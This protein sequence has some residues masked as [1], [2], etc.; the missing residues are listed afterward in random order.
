MKS[1]VTKGG[2]FSPRVSVWRKGA[3]V[4]ADG[5]RREG[6]DRAGNGEG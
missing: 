1:G 2:S 3:A 4:A 6:E 5:A